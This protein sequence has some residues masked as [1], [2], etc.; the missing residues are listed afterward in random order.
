MMRVHFSSSWAKSPDVGQKRSPPANLFPSELAYPP[1]QSDTLTDFW[2][3]A[4]ANLLHRFSLALRPVLPVESVEPARPLDG[5]MRPMV[6]DTG[7][8]GVEALAASWSPGGRAA[9][10][11]AHVGG[12][13]CMRP[14]AAEHRPPARPQHTAA[15]RGRVPDRGPRLSAPPTAR[16]GCGTSR[17]VGAL[18]C[19][20]AALSQPR[21]GLRGVP[22]LHP[23]IITPPRPR[24][25]AVSTP[26]FPSGQ[27]RPRGV[28]LSHDWI[29]CWGHA[30]MVQGKNA[31]QRFTGAEKGRSTG[32]TQEPQA[33]AFAPCTAS[34]RRKAPGPSSASFD[35]TGPAKAIVRANWAGGQALCSSGLCWLG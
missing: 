3:P 34:T 32:F 21:G 35:P 8:G 22:R 31:K 14:V 4:P 29:L 11:D 24:P 20:R 9:E 5:V 17:D 28:W 7:W 26:F 10:K 16:T 27:P 2:N 18:H 30:A 33:Q 1:A 23:S 19:P 13:A 12:Q 15:V 25:A 6:T